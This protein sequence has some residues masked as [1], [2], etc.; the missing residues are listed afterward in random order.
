ME[1]RRYGLGSI[2]TIKCDC[3]F[4]QTL[5]TD[6][7]H[8][9]SDVGIPVWDV[10]IFPSYSILHVIPLPT[11]HIRLSIP[12]SLLSTVQFISVISGKSESRR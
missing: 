4:G 2:L 1:E 9:A 6:K 10:N 12:N 8:R 3:G 11:S 7:S 5:Y